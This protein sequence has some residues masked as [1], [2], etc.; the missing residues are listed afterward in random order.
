MLTHDDR[1]DGAAV[2]VQ[3][4]PQQ[5]AQAGGVQYRARPHHPVGRVA[6][7]AERGVGQH[8]HGV[9]HD[10]QDALKGPGGNLRDDG[11][12]NIHVLADELQTGLARLLVG[13]GGDDDEGAVG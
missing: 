3:V 13:S 4:F 11:V 12:E 7:Y 10:E 9:G 8:I 5:V 1:V 6:G 2:H